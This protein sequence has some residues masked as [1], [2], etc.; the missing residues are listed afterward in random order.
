[1]ETVVIDQIEGVVHESTSLE[2]VAVEQVEQVV[3]L[4]VKETFVV[5]SNPDSITHTNVEV[6][7]VVLGGNQGIQGPPGDSTQSVYLLSS[8]P[9][10]GN[11]IVATNALG[12]LVYPDP[13]LQQNTLVGITKHSATPD[14]LTE[15]QIT[16]IMS[17]P[18]WSWDTTQPIYW[19]ANGILTQVPPTIGTLQ[20]VGY[21]VTP[22][23]MIIDK[24]TP[25][26]LG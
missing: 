14:Q 18:S 17:E 4:D 7:A 25:I 12:K 2:S 26:T 11:R 3:L 20:V 10:G 24:Q 8:I 21:P 6:Q 15:V 13:N 9:V 19:T 23:S 1:M 22:T 5:G 16:G